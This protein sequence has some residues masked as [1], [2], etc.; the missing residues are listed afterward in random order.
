MLD[1]SGEAQASSSGPSDS[2]AAAT[3]TALYGA[4]RA[5]AGLGKLPKVGFTICAVGGP[6]E[7]EIA[8]RLKFVKLLLNIK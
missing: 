2:M 1:A 5:T 8:F 4:L 6:T 3:A 7:S